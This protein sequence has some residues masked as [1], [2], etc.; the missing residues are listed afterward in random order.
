MKVRRRARVAVLQALF[1]IDLAGHDPESVITKRLAH[2]HLPPAAEA[3]A[4]RLL[5]GVLT[6]QAALDR[7]IARYAPEWP[8]E[9]MAAIDRNILRIA[10]YELAAEEDIP[11]RVAINEAVELAK[12]F[13]SDASP[14][15]VNGV[16][17]SAVAHERASI[18][19]HLGDHKESPAVK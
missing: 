9:Q 15:F 13:G 11:V 1:E 16:L 3:F 17:G 12:M 14:R 19:P 8:V 10:L 6:H 18:L 2:V 7:V 5:R 4:R